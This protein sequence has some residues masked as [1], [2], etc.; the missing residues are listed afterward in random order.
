MNLSNYIHRCAPY[1]AKN[2]MMAIIKTESRGNPLMIGL[3][4][5]YRL[6]YQP[7]NLSQANK[8]V[9]YLERHGYNFD[10]GIAQVNISNIH[11]Y[12]YTARDA[13]D[14]CLNIK[15]SGHILLRHYTYALP[16]SKTKQEALLKSISAYNTGSY[17]KGFDNGYVKRVLSN[18][19]YF[20]HK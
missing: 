7:H 20:M 17:R 5:G 1:I 16:V 13:L 2:T 4:R 12:G 18:A 10:V 11:R 9:D 3:N 15:L 8:W 6:I 14:P 19:S